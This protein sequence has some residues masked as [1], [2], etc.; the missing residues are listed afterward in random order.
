MTCRVVDL[1]STELQLRSAFI[2]THAMSQEFQRDAL[3]DEPLN[4]IS[5]RLNTIQF[6]SCQ[7]DAELHQVRGRLIKEAILMGASLN[8]IPTNRFYHRSDLRLCAGRYDT[9]TYLS[10]NCSFELKSAAT[11]FS[12]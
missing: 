8:L 2:C 1:T 9:Q 11:T 5:A 12:I 3:P 6:R 7:L 10:E 4:A